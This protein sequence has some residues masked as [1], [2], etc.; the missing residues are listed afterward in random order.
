MVEGN[1]WMWQVLNIKGFGFILK[2]DGFMF[3]LGIFI[4]GNGGIVDYWVLFFDIWIQEIWDGIKN[5]YFKK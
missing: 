3:F 2:G 5:L 4:W 1:V